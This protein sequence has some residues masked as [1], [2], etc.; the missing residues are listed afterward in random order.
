[1]T[2]IRLM[3]EGDRKVNGKKQGAVDGYGLMKI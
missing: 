3:V 1:M 2:T